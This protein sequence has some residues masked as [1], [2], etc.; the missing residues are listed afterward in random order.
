MFGCCT[1]MW[2][3]KGRETTALNLEV[4]CVIERGNSLF[5]TDNNY[6]FMVRLL[7]SYPPGGQVKC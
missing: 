7:L 3:L 1:W 2:R 5:G 4:L 6:G